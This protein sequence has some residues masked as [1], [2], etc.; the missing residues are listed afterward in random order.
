MVNSRC[1]LVPKRLRILR[2]FG[3]PREY[4]ESAAQ[5][6]QITPGPDCFMRL[7]P[8]ALRRNLVTADDS[9]PSDVRELQAYF[10]PVRPGQERGR[11]GH[12]RVISRRSGAG[13]TTLLDAFSSLLVPPRW[14]DFNAAMAEQ[15]EQRIPLMSTAHVGKGWAGLYDVSR[16]WRGRLST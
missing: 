7:K 15:T 4:D 10:A 9:F 14:V 8:M 16:D 3:F 1:S 11:V 12:G 5:G 6:R 2:S 13:K